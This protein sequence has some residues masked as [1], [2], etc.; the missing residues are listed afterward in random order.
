MY[1]IFLLIAL[2]I[3]FFIQ[4]YERCSTPFI[5]NNLQVKTCYHMTA[6][7]VKYYL[8]FPFFPIN[9]KFILTGGPIAL[10]LCEGNKKEYESIIPT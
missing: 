6:F 1:L 9:F 3:S 8:K 2:I 7:S 10:F 5:N 4:P